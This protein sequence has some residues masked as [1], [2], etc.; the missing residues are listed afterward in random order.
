MKLNLI[1]G[2]RIQKGHKEIPLE[3]EDGKT[4][5]FNVNMEVK[6]IHGFSGHSNRRQL[7]EFAKRLHPRPDKI[8][9]CHGDPYKTVDL[10]SSIHRS[11]KIETK[12]PLN[13]ECTR[14]Q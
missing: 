3:G 14:I 8:L 7:M 10:A 6:T 2:R 11:Y 12:S 9:T 4:K 1:Y 13:L 5:V